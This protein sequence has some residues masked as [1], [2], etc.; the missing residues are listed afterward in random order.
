MIVVIAR[1]II[2]ATVVVFPVPIIFPVLVVGAWP[3]ACPI[4]WSVACLSSSR[5][6][7]DLPYWH[8]VPVEQVVFI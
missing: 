4:G 7:F 8:G 3:V 1:V 2:V 6:W 5:L